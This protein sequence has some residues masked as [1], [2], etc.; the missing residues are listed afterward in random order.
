M[1]LTKK[2]RICHFSSVHTTIDTRVFYR[3]CVSLAKQHEVTLIAIGNKSG[4]MNGVNVIGL[5]KPKG[6]ISRILFFTR[7][8]YQLA[9]QT[10]TDIYHF[11]DPELIPYAILLKR[12]GKKVVYDI[13]ENVTESMKAKDWLPLKW[14]FISVYLLFDNWA[15]KHMEMILAEES[16]VQVYKNRYPD[17]TV[18]VIRNFASPDM[19][20]TYAT[21]TRSNLSPHIFYMGSID[22]LYCIRPMIESIWELKK[23]GF[24]T[25]L[26]LVGWLNPKLEEEIHGWPFWNEIKDQVSFRGYLDIKDGYRISMECMMG[27]SFVSNNKNVKES[28][29]RKLYEY[30]QVGL[31]VISSGHPLYRKVVEENGIG[32]CVQDASAAAIA[33]AVEQLLHDPE[34]LN[35]FA[36]NGI[37]AG[38]KKYNWQDEEQRLLAF[39]KNRFNS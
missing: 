22:H 3:E 8:V 4:R 2:L 37:I 35:T 38:K 19:M 39:Y 18:E 33:D 36:V 20:E 28:I 29:P 23:R 27:F 17:K 10:D 6:R 16:Y 31:P 13:H 34:R 9:K 5:P 11:H 1:T 32:I 30:M 12:Q 24:Q 25:T 15:A 7:K 21:T 26:I 14:L